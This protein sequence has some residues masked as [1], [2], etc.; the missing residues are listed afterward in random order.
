MNQ[1][2]TIRVLLASSI[3]LMT[4]TGCLKTRSELEA[5]RMNQ[6]QERQTQTQ[7]RE[8][9][10]GEVKEYKEKAP[11]S[12]YRFEEYDEQMRQLSGRVDSLESALAQTH[13]GKQ[14]EKEA[15]YK[16][17][18]ALE[19]KFL[20]YEE[21]IKKVE[22]QLLIANEE[23]ARLKAPPPEPP[24]A[25]S[26]R[27]SFDLGEEQFAARKWKTAITNFQKYREQNPKGKLYVSATLKIGLSFKELGMKDEAKAFLEEVIAKSPKSIEAKKAAAQ[28]KS[29]K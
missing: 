28:M 3:G 1:R 18:Q 7:Q 10:K 20:A 8:H 9:A 26:G 29:L 14:G 23:I 22:A 24:S 15:A 19:Q 17:R 16:E 2:S 11:P 21:A 5:E 13:S 6:Q 4:F 27:E 25:P 12:A